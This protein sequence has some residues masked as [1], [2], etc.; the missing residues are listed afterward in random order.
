ME[1]FLPY[2]EETAMAITRE[3]K[4]IISKIFRRF[5]GRNKLSKSF[6]C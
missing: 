4:R 6:N 5:K 1:R 3:G 2:D